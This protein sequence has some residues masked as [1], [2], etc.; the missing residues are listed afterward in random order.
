M[1]NVKTVSLRVS[2]LSLAIV[3]ILLPARLGAAPSLELVSTLGGYHLAVAAEGNLVYLGEGPHLVVLDVSDPDAPR[4]VSRTRFGGIFQSIL[5]EGAEVFV[6]ADGLGILQIDLSPPEAPSLVKT[7]GT[8]GHRAWDVAISGSLAYVAGVDQGFQVIDLTSSSVLASRETTGDA[9]AVAVSG[10][11]AYVGDSFAGLLIYDISDPSSPEFLGSYQTPG[12]HATGR[13]HDV[14]VSGGVAFVADGYGGLQVVDVQ[15]PG[16][17]SALPALQTTLPV[18]RLSL[19][20]S[21]LFAADSRGFRIY[22]ISDP[23]HAAE[24]GD[25][26]DH[27][28]PVAVVSAGNLALLAQGAH[29]MRVFDI[30]TLPTPTPRGAYRMFG[31]GWDIAFENSRI[32][33]ADFTS[34][35]WMIDASNP[36]SPEMLVNYPTPGLEP[37]VQLDGDTLYVSDREDFQVLNVSDPSS[38]ERIGSVPVYTPY[39]DVLGDTAFLVSTPSFKTIS[40]ADPSSPEPLGSLLITGPPV[41][42]GYAV[43]VSGSHAYI[44]GGFGG[45]GFQVIDVS[46]PA[47]PEEGAHIDGVYGGKDVLIDGTTVFYAGPHLWAIDITDPDDP[48]VIADLP[49]PGY[50]QGLDLLGS[51]LCAANDEQ[52]VQVVDVTH[53][54]SMEE[55]ASADTPGRARDVAVSGALIAVADDLGGLAIFRYEDDQAT[56][57]EIIGALLGQEQR[58]MWQDVNGDGEIDVGDVVTEVLG[59]SS[60]P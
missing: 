27:Q 12:G 16:H 31:D 43:A 47:S 5:L 23:R 25:A 57:E 50:R 44:A 18:W 33:F 1:W 46:N 37:R 17:P 28:S 3:S 10:E 21:R 15:D 35:L 42:N 7:I 30:Q 52:G 9:Q 59:P 39:F 49:P 13:A 14:A 48:T 29:G 53:P 36:A 26:E 4:V 32:V 24:I 56:L 51:L 19:E 55:V 58:Q 38:P 54:A 2:A 34:G 11:R 22:D 8:S 45:R 6:A 40:L 41:L 60:V 20:G